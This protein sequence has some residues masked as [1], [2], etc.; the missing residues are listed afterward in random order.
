MKKKQ[1]AFF[2]GGLLVCAQAIATSFTTYVVNGTQA[3]ESEVPWQAYITIAE[4]ACG[5]TIIADK[6][7]LTAAH[8]V[9]GYSASQITVYVGSSDLTSL[10]MQTIAVSTMTVNPGYSSSTSINDIAILELA[11]SIASPAQPIKLMSVSEQAEA[12]LEFDLATSDNLFLSGWGY[13][14][15]DRTASSTDLMKVLLDGVSDDACADAWGVSSSGISAYFLC[16]NSA[17]SEGA[18]NGDSGGPLVWQNK[19]NASDADKGYRLAGLVSFGPTEQCAMTQYPDV[20][21]QVSSQL[22]WI[23]GIIT[24]YTEPAPSFSYDIFAEPPVT[25]SSS[26]SSGGG[27]VGGISLGLLCGLAWLRRKVYGK[28]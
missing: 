14:N 4:Y 17:D 19:N 16:A 18:C 6:W 23:T 12:D 9:E 15:A 2:L 5:G 26:S 24:D 10:S 13:T 1:L 11:H 20:Y 7:V 22:S 3:S 21:T 28:N 25:T 27:P 8:C